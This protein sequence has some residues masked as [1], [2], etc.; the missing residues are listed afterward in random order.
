MVLP[1]VGV[2]LV[3]LLDW[4][5]WFHRLIAGQ[6]LCAAAIGYWLAVNP[7]SAETPGEPEG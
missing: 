6:F 2:I 7:S 5:L 4:A 3:G 1:A